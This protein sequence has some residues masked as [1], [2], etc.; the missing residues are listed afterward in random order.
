MCIFLLV[1]GTILIVWAISDL[2]KPINSVYGDYGFILFG[3]LLY[4]PAIYYLKRVLD[5]MLAKTSQEKLEI[6]SEI[7]VELD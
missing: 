1:T 7:P 2:K 6:L 5:F 3:F 4:I